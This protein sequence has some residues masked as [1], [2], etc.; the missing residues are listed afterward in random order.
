MVIAGILI[1][2]FCVFENTVAFLN[3]YLTIAVHSYVAMNIV[4][5]KAVFF[6]VPHALQL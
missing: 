4:I 6:K 3:H 1:Y 2:L 5:V